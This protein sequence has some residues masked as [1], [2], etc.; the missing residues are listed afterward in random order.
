LYF[1]LT[2]IDICELVHLIGL[3]SGTISKSS[4]MTQCRIILLLQP[5]TKLY[6][7]TIELKLRAD[8][9]CFRSKMCFRTFSTESL[10]SPMTIQTLEN[11]NMTISI[12]YQLSLQLSSRSV[13]TY[14]SY[15][16]YLR[17]FRLP[18]DDAA[19]SE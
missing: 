4:Q 1:L 16:S 8:F 15:P 10:N 18:N 5:I 6:L 19:V 14:P 11:S 3:F 12:D 13:L 9:R 2:N 17:F 7:F